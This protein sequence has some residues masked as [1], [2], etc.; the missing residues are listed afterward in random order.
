M[1]DDDFPFPQVGY[2][3]SLEGMY[4]NMQLSEI[5]QTSSLRSIRSLREHGLTW[6]DCHTELK[7]G[8]KPRK[9][10][11]SLEF[12]IYEWDIQEDVSVLLKE[13][14]GHRNQMD[15]AVAYSLWLFLGQMFHRVDLHFS[16]LLPDVW[17]NNSAFAA[18]ATKIV[19]FMLYLLSQ[20]LTFKLLGIIHLVQKNKV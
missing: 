2:A 6:L 15:L 3:N 4:Y 17:P 13:I 7:I 19:T 12:F 11:L 5:Y 20:W 10:K 18:F 9:A 1:F 16:S 8:W 14:V